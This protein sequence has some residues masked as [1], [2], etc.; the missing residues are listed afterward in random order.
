MTLHRLSWFHYLKTWLDEEMHYVEIA[1]ENDSFVA[2]LKKIHLGLLTQGLGPNQYVD[3]FLSTSPLPPCDMLRIGNEIDIIS[4]L[5]SAVCTINMDQPYIALDDINHHMLFD[6]VFWL[7]ANLNY[8]Y[9]LISFPNRLRHNPHE[10][11]LAL[12]QDQKSCLIHRRP[13]I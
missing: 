5:E 6:L 12:W 10:I 13:A 9:V 11:A 2:D 4:A 7:N 3:D 1:R 8:Q